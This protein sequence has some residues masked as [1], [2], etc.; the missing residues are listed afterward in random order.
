MNMEYL[1][2]NK[3][4]CSYKLEFRINSLPVV[5]YSNAVKKMH[6]FMMRTQFNSIVP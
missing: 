5:V 4:C 1:P 3:T 2:Q 6:W